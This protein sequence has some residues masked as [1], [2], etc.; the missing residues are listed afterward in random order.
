MAKADSVHSTPPTNTSAIRGSQPSLRALTFFESLPP[1]HKTFHVRD[2]ASAPHLK[3]GEFAVIDTRDTELQKG[4]VYLIQYESGRR[5]RY[6]VQI[7]TGKIGTLSG[8]QQIVWWACDLA[9]F[10]RVDTMPNGIPCFAG[11]SDG[12]YSPKALRRRLLGRLVGYSETALGGL[13]NACAE[14]A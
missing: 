12:P 5:S 14:P 6:L 8:R 4:E 1:H 11:V 9:G 13:L 3:P 10:R 7:N 2:G